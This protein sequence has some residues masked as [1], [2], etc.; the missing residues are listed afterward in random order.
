MVW[1]WTPNPPSESLLAVRFRHRLHK[2]D[3]VFYKI[4]TRVI[5]EHFVDAESR[6]AAAHITTG[7]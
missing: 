3:F 4:Y 6:Y 5:L 1:Q 7:V 2:V